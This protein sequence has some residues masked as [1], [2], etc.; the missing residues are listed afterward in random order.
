MKADYVVSSA[1]AKL[2]RCG[3]KF[4]GKKIV[5]R[6]PGI[7]GWGAVDFL[8]KRGYYPSFEIAPVVKLQAMSQAKRRKWRTN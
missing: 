5:G 1:K 2:I 3:L 6:Q 4:E 7:A 8:K